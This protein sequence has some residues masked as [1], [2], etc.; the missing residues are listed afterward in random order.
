MLFFDGQLLNIL[1]TCFCPTYFIFLFFC[2]A[3]F[4]AVFDSNIPGNY[5]IS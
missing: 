5:P 1:V 3:G 4:V 2:Y